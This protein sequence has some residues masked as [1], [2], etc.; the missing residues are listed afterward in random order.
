MGGMIFLLI[1]LCIEIFI[2]I[3]VFKWMKI[4]NQN[5]LDK[6]KKEND[7]D[8]VIIENLNIGISRKEKKIKL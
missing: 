4:R 6:L 3:K 7:E 1:F 5:A 2:G 8:G